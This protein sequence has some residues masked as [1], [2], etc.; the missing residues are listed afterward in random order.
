MITGGAGLNN[1]VVGNYDTIAGGT[2]TGLDTLSAGSNSVVTAAASIAVG[3]SSA[4]NAG[5]GADLVN[6]GKA[7][8]RF[9]EADSPPPRVPAQP[10]RVSLT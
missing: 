9:R 2:G 5:P 10:G 1:I 4:V 8:H 6:L 3:N 7:A